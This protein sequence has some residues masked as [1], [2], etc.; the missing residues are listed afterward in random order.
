MALFG[1]ILLVVGFVAI[2]RAL[3]LAETGL[4]VA[5]EAQS[6]Q[7]VVRSKSLTDDEKEA[8]M[9]AAT[10]KLFRQFFTLAFGGAAALLL[11]LAAVWVSSLVGIFN[12]DAV[13]ATSMS[14]LFLVVTGAVACVAMFWQPKQAVTDATSAYSTTDRTLHQLAFNTITAQLGLADIEDRVY[15]RTLKAYPA[16]R[17]IFVTGLPRA[18]TT[19]LL[20]CFARMP[21]FASHCYRDMPFVLTPMFWDRFSSA[22]RTTGKARERAHGDGMTID[23][24]SPEALEEVIWQAFW[25][26]AYQAD[27]IEPWKSNPDRDF[28]AFFQSHMRKIAAVRRP[29]NSS[30][31]RYVSKNNLNIAR[32]PLIRQSFPDATIVVPFRQPLDHAASLLKQHQ[33]FSAIH[34][35]DPFAADYMRDLGHFDFGSNLRPID[36]DGWLADNRHESNTLAFWLQ[37]WTATYRHLLTTD[38]NAQFFSYDHLCSNPETSLEALASVLHC[39]DKQ[40]LLNAAEDM[41]APRPRTVDATSTPSDLLAEANAIYEDLLAVELTES[42]NASYHASSVGGWS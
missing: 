24:D 15:S 41:H 39:R 20:E 28:T 32:L 7:A 33:N 23:F 9:K 38:C 4:A 17:P 2:F 11:P 31:V 5:K 34:R 40:R 35:D 6:A 18:G 8:A 42:R 14:P 26:Q 36:F 27:R 16:D 22:F 10:R 21:E 30:G 37:Y 1:A 12:I 13:I 25:P 3:D 19:L 29:E